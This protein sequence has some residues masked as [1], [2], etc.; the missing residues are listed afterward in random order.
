MV[1]V[2]IKVFG[3]ERAEKVIEKLRVHGCT[4]KNLSLSEDWREPITLT[5]KCDSEEVVDEVLREIKD[6]NTFKKIL[7]DELT[8]YPRWE[9]RKNRK[10]F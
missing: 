5:A 2:E 6:P 8:P 10:I 3:R 7:P 1:D 9:I 4:V